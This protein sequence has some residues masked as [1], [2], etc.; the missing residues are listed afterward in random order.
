MPHLAKR[1]TAYPKTPSALE[2]INL[3]LAEA[4]RACGFQ[5]FHLPLA[6]DFDRCLHCPTCPGY[7]CPNGS[8]ASSLNRCVQPAVTEYGAELWTDTDALALSHRGRE[9]T[10]VRVQSRATGRLEEI[11]ARLYVL[12]AGTIGTPVLLLTSGLAG[13]SGQV[14][15][16][17]MYHAGAVVA[18]VFMSSTG[19]AT[20]FVKQLGFT[21]LYLGAP[22]FPHKLGSVQ[23]LPVPGPL[24]MKRQ[25]SMPT[26]VA[27]W[28][29]RRTV[30]LSGVVEDLPLSTNRVEVGHQG[31]IVVRH[32][33]HPYDRYRS[34]YMLAQLRKVLWRAGAWLLV[35][36]T[37]ERDTS[38][39]SHQVGTCRFGTDPAT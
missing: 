12:A 28:L 25:I 21:D 14:G 24:S 38:R 7:V 8:R 26:P 27:S 18:G 17:Y 32:T 11:T 29:Y 4:M 39:T 1:P 19:G 20:R 35:G 34:R 22:N 2:P 5:P 16:N 3:R 15:R 10:S 9:V 30:L 23:V 31:H 37:N 6:I 13:R 36:A 33:Y